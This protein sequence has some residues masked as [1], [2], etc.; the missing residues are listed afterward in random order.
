MGIRVLVFIREREQLKRRPCKSSL[1]CLWCQMPIQYIFFKSFSIPPQAAILIL[2]QLCSRQRY[3]GKM[4]CSDI[5]GGNGGGIDFTPL[6]ISLIIALTLLAVCNPPRRRYV[7]VH[8][9]YPRWQHSILQ[10][11]YKSMLSSIFGCIIYFSPSVTNTVLC[12]VST[13]NMR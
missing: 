1:T 6:L 9:M 3:M 5:C 7:A 2:A 12:M 11:H 8:P 13:F 4:I 10:Q